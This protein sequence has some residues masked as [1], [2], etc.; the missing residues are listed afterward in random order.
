MAAVMITLGTVHHAMTM[1][2]LHAAMPLL[3]V[4]GVCMLGV[5]LVFLAD[6]VASLTLDAARV[7]RVRGPLREARGRLC[8]DCL[9]DLRGIGDEGACPECGEA[10]SKES[11]ADWWG[12]VE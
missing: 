10:F 3:P 9:H 7:R 8:P 5:P 12:R 1:V 11:L 4:F 2:N 6:A